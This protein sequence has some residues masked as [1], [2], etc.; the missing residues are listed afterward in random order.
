[1]FTVGIAITL[2][3]MVLLCPLQSSVKASGF[4]AA[5]AHFHGDAGGT[6]LPSEGDSAVCVDFHSVLANLF[7]NTIVFNTTM[8]ISLFF[9]FSRLSFYLFGF[10]DS[11]YSSIIL[12]FRRRKN[13]YL[14][15]IRLLFESKI[16]MWN[17]FVRSGFDTLAV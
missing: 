8:I 10:L 12:Y 5:A 14:T 9:V 15:T 3:L 16:R 2:S 13:L 4:G 7:S 1:M 11:I 6:H 17:T